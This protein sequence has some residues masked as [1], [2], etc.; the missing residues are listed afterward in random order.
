MALP[1]YKT[2]TGTDMF[3]RRGEALQSKGKWIINVLSGS[4]A[5][6]RERLSS[7]ETQPDQQSS[8][9]SDGET[10]SCWEM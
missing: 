3:D 2:L 8:S 4:S 6:R 7:R 9:A 5:G 10:T 1:L